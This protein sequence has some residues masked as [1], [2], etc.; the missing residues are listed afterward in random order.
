MRV[1]LVGVACVGKTTIGRHLA[2][3]L[4]C[5]FYDLDE[6][7][8]KFYGAPIERL[9]E[10]FGTMEVFR[11]KSALVITCLASRKEAEDFLIAL[12]PR[13]LMGPYLRAVQLAD[14]L[15]V[16]LKDKPEN[17][18][19]RLAF[20]DVDSR[21]IEKHLTPAEKRLY[22]KEIKADMAYFGRSYRKADLTVDLSDTRSVEE[23]AA[24]ILEEIQCY[25]R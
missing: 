16:A 19:A 8:E 9:Q 1:F 12:P 11:K 17:V 2:A 22:L 21:P 3:R 7:V 25:A 24:E 18:L 10:R 13:G 15:T 6:E 14:G 5:S 20:F 4:G 23:A